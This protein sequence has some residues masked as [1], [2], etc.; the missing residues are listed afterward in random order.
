MLLFCVYHVSFM[1]FLVV[2]DF[3][4]LNYQYDAGM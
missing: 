1:D 2:W 4:T 3:R